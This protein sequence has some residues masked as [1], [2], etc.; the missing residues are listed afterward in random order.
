MTPEYELSIH[1]WREEQFFHHCI[2]L[3][4]VTDN[5][6]FNELYK[7]VQTWCRD[8]LVSYEYTL[9]SVINGYYFN[10]IAQTEET[11]VAMK[12]RWL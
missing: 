11:M 8:N 2:F 7:E 1:R 3:F 5:Q 6:D 10:L 9:E 12:L 4:A